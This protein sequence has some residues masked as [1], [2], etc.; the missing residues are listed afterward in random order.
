MVNTYDIRTHPPPQDGSAGE[1]K[2]Y[3]DRGPQEDNPSD[4]GQWKP[5]KSIPPSKHHL[6]ASGSGVQDPA[7]AFRKRKLLAGECSAVLSDLL[8]D[9]IASTGEGER[10]SC[11]SPSLPLRFY[12]SNENETKTPAGWLEGAPEEGLD[13]VA[14]E[15]GDME[16]AV[17]SFQR[18]VVLG[19]DEPSSAYNVQYK[20][21]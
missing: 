7:A 2:K 15:E 20:V 1:L 18:C 9:W 10:V 5:D 13:A 3:V 14:F 16:Q 12:D 4:L 19:Y 8:A 17:G 6:L 11:A 21:T